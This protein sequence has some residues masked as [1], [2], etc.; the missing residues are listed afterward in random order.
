MTISNYQSKISMVSAFP[1]NAKELEIL[2]Q[3]WKDVCVQ[4]DIEA[5]ITPQI[6]KLV[7]YSC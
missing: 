5:H 1:D 3:V 2:A 6:A 7:K 4:L